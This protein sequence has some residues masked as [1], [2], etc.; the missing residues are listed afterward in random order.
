MRDKCDKHATQQN[1]CY[2]TGYHNEKQLTCCFCKM[3][4]FSVSQPTVRRLYAN[5]KS[6]FLRTYSRHVGPLSISLNTSLFWHR[7]T[8]YSHYL[9]VTF[10]SL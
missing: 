4:A 6:K 8:L 2:L 3:E 1:V 5:D 7:V 10:L 9:V